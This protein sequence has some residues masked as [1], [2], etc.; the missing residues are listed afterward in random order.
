MDEECIHIVETFAAPRGNFQRPYNIKFWPDWSMSG[1]RSS[2][3]NKHSLDCKNGDIDF[4]ISLGYGVSRT[5]V[6]SE[7]GRTR[8]KHRSTVQH[9]PR[10]PLCPQTEN[11]ADYANTRT[12]IGMKFFTYILQKFDRSPY[13]VK[14][15]ISFFLFYFLNCF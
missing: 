15:R 1:V 10:T 12:R 6:S 2:V 14:Q 11:V 8:W 9:K 3:C 7:N 4:N 13:L 5:Q